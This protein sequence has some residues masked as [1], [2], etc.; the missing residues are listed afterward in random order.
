MLLRRGGLTSQMKKQKN[1]AFENLSDKEKS[2]EN[3]IILPGG[4]GGRAKKFTA[5]FNFDKIKEKFDAT[6]KLELED[7]NNAADIGLFLDWYNKTIKDSA[8]KRATEE[9]IEISKFLARTQGR[10]TFIMDSKKV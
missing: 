4:A 3:K 6:G 8:E 1:V 7:F 9:I 5:K 2:G 10:K